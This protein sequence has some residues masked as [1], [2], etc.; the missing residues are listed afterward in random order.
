M[1]EHEL[2]I[3]AL[4]N[5]HLAVVAN[6]VLGAAGVH[7]HNPARPWANFVVME[8]LVAFIIMAV[9]ALLR[10]RLSMDK[11]SNFQQTFELV[12]T[13]LRDL[14]H[15]TVG[16]GAKPFVAIAGTF[17]IFILFGNLIGIIPGFESPTMF[18]PVPL[19]CALAAFLYYNA[20]GI[21]HQGIIGYLKHLAGPVWWLAPLFFVIEIISHLARPLSLTVRLYANMF[22]GEQVTLVFLGLVPIAI[23]AVF[24]GL[25][26]FVSFVQAYIFTVLTLIYIGGMVE[27]EEH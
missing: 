24:M 12:Y 9:F 7:A 3:T 17:F 26:V 23:P 21:K 22:A 5:D 20:I 25:H 1:P 19:G 2:W 8:I 6:A 27:H 11:P 13:F 10:A 18:A 15:E 14:A 16:H 4:F